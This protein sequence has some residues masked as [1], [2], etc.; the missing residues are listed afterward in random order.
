MEIEFDDDDLDRLET[1]A[2][3]SAGHGPAV[4]RAF[5]KTLQALRAAVDERDLYTGGLQFEKMKGDRKHERSVRL[6]KQWRL[7][8]QIRGQGSQK[9]IAVVRIEDY[10]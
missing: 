8:V 9:R 7:I 3:F 5:R 6:N 1:D 4:D 10:H 2:G